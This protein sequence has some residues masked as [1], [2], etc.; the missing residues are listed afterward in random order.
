MK[1]ANPLSSAGTQPA[2]QSRDQAA[3]KN[4]VLVHGAFADGSG[5]RGVHEELTRRGY[6]VAIVQKSAHLTGRRRRRDE[7]GAGPDRGRRRPGRRFLGWN[8]HH[9]S[10]GAPQGREPGLRL[11][12]GPRRRCCAVIGTEDNAFGQGMRQAMAKRIGARITEVPASHALFMTQARAVA[13]VIDD[14]AR[15]QS[16]HHYPNQNRGPR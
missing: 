10:G 7:T 13:D 5:W 16:P 14:A 9:G 4:V 6:R 1:K 2:L 11:R 12:V 8:G 3:V 15:S